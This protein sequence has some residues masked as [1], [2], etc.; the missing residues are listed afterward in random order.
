MG[1]E[2]AELG[3]AG[4][5]DALAHGELRQPPRVE[6]R[7]LQPRLGLVLER[8]LRVD[9]VAGGL[10]VSIGGLAGQQ[11]THDLRGTLEDTVDTRVA[12]LLLGGDGA[13]AARPQRLG[14]LVATPPRT[15]T[16]S[17]AT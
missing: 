12:Q 8:D 13:F 11:Q 1:G 2:V 14:G 16:S 9:D 6:P 4:R 15:W 10:Q 3:V 17:S 7:G 5:D